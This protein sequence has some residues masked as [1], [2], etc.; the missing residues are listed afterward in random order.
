L[1]AWGFS[2]A[3]DICWSLGHHE[4][5]KNWQ[6]STIWGWLRRRVRIEAVDQF[7]VDIGCVWCGCQ[8]FIRE[9]NWEEIRPNIPRESQR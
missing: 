2:F 7:G 3:I 5:M 1:A 4:T 9:K 6:V 8:F